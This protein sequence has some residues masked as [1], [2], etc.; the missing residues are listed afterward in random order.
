MLLRVL[1]I[2]VH[3]CLSQEVYVIVKPAMLFPSLAIDYNNDYDNEAILR[4]NYAPYPIPTYDN[5]ESAEVLPLQRKRA[6]DKAASLTDGQ[7][8]CESTIQYDHAPTEGF[9]TNNQLVEVQQDSERRLITNFIECTASD[10]SEKLGKGPV[11]PECLAIDKHL[12]AGIRPKGSTGPFQEGKIKVPVTCEC[13]VQR[14]TS[15]P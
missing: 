2:F 10:D 3:I 7:S 8:V 15:Q 4:N 9:D 6:A 11:N 5:S 13:R 12:A 1:V 14:K